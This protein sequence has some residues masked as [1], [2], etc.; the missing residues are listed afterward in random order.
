MDYFFL[1]QV[2]MDRFHFSE[3]VEK[4]KTKLSFLKM[5]VFE[6]DNF[7]NLKKEVKNPKIVHF[8]ILSFFS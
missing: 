3:D 2:G 5:I 1:P 7:F 6:K 4:R 8:Q